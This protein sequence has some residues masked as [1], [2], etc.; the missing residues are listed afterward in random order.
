LLI[1]R[2][3]LRNYRVF[4]DEL[5]LH[6]PPGLVG[7]YGPNGAGKSTLLEAIVWA[8]WGRARTPK[9]GIPSSGAHGECV[10]EL[11]FEQEGHIYLVRRALSGVNATVKAG[12]H[13]DGQAMAEG[14]RDTSRYVHSVLGMDD[15]AFRASVFAEQKQ[16]AAFSEQGPAERRKLVLGLLGV[17]PLDAAR[18]R[19]RADA[20]ES[21]QQ[22]NRLRSMLPD[23]EE[24]RLAAAD[25]EAQAGA[26]DV[27]ADEEEK[28][29]AAVRDL[30]RSSREAFERLDL[31][32]QEHEL[33]LMEGKAARAELDAADRDV[34][35]LAAEL[36]TL[37]EVEARLAELT[38]VAQRLPSAEKQAQLVAGVAVA[39][40]DLG[41]LPDSAPPPPPDEE[42]LA[43]AAQA[44]MTARSALGSAQAGRQ[45]ASDQRARAK[46][47]LEKS[48]SLSGEGD[49]PLC[50]QTLGEAFAKVQ[51]HRAGEVDA[52]QEQLRRADEALSQAT[53][54][55]QQAVDDLGKLQAQMEAARLARSKWEQAQARRSSALER[56]GTA[57][58]SLAEVDS[59]LATRLESAQG[60]DDAVR[61]KREAEAE[62]A[63][64]RTAQDEVG[65]LQGRLERRAAAEL[66]RHRA[67]E[68]AA[69]A[70]SLVETLRA[71]VKGLAFDSAALT[72]AREAL[73][74]AQTV[75][76]QADAAAR[77]SRLV[78]ATS[79]A[80][81]VAEAKR[82]SEAEAQHA[83]LADLE[84]ASVHL[85]RTA[86]LLNAFRNSVV[87][88]VGPRLAVQAAEL[89]DELTDG[90]YDRLEVDTDTYGLRI[91]DGGISYDLERFSGS[92]VDLANLA[93]RVAISEHVRFQSGGTVGLLVLDEVFGPLDE[94][95]KT[96]MLMALERL[97]GRFRQI[98]VVTH[99]TEI[100]E[101]LPHAIEVVKKPGRR[102]TARVLGI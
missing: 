63:A 100:K 48:E 6:I 80:E 42:R 21:T 88:S 67:E 81:A 34:A 68:R 57:L 20:R 2:I 27:A 83:L 56:L 31:L 98:L 32:R 71:K 24:A 65:R 23:L 4:E 74:A 91:S 46:Q 99:S 16:L 86:E 13:C 97:R 28:A 93:L 90:D 33:L 49:C 41:A 22:H 3:Y 77:R 15:A 37:A 19:A 60:T 70:K 45:A 50:G 11:T 76:E 26:A 94:E 51:A 52:A 92:E 39:A 30:A 72:R 38:P 89:F 87:A 75:A 102:A 36:S 95:R 82:V 58:A 18:D 44:A 9:E 17:T 7:I 10:V 96:R 79:R 66:A 1:D 47:A 54:S 43:T 84:S 78:A 14:P 40:K 25:K 59:P 64:C 62:L 101:Q 85:S 69:A 12:A 61:A 55:A 5:E 73:G 29:A 53:K 35:N 8:L